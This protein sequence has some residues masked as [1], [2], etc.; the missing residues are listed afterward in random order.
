M[1]VYVR[2]CARVCVCVC[3]CLCVRVLA[4]NIVTIIILVLMSTFCSCCKARCAHPSV[5]ER[6]GAVET[7]AIIIVIII[8]I[9]IIIR[10]TFTLGTSVGLHTYAQQRTELVLLKTKTVSVP[11]FGITA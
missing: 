6:C 9:I 5:S 2:A 3:V 11:A 1:C 8:N 7:T 10:L 4:C